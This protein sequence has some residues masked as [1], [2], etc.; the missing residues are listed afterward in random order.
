M[1]FIYHNSIGKFQQANA[2]TDCSA[3]PFR[4][5]FLRGCIR[6][7]THIMPQQMINIACGNKA[8]LFLSCTA[9][10]RFVTTIHIVRTI[11]ETFCVCVCD[12][13]DMLQK[14]I[15]SEWKRANLPI[16]YG[17]YK[18]WQ[19]QI[20]GQLLAHST[21]LAK[22]SIEHCAL[23]G[24]F[25]HCHRPPTQHPISAELAVLINPMN[26]NCTGNAVDYW[27]LFARLALMNQIWWAF[28]APIHL[29]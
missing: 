26:I 4:I 13:F 7:C 20:M 23:Y 27:G 14:P 2:Y 1:I 24:C 19:S 3:T 15:A 12:Y 16:Y 29:F 18:S 6:C 17:A 28:M 25:I 22:N 9:A 8:Q 10:R 11:V 21:H 5:P